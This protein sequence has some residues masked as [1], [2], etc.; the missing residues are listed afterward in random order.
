MADADEGGGGWLGDL[1]DSGDLH[2]REWREAWRQAED[3]ISAGDDAALRRVLADHPGMAGD[4]TI[5]EPLL[6]A[7]AELGRGGAVAAL[8]EAGV[9][10]NSINANGGTALMDAAWNG[11]AAVVRLLLDAGADPDI[12]VEEQCGRGDPEVV[13]RCALFFALVKGHREVVE[14]LEPL[15]DPAV[16][17]LAYREL[18]GHLQWLAENPPPHGPTVHLF[19]ACQGQRPDRLRAAIAAGGD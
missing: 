8:L 15:T 4:V 16:R 18:P 2:P 9:P 7:A 10:A 13:G 12:L 5:N 6:T 11:H 14:L 19:V 3:A 17:A 1:D